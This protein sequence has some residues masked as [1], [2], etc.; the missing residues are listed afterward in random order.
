M[1]RRVD[2]WLRLR[3][4]LLGPI[5]AR[6]TLRAGDSPRD[7]YMTGVLAPADA[8]ELD[9]SEAE[10]L[11]PAA[12]E[13]PN[14]ADDEESAILIA[15][16]GASF[17]DPKALPHSFGLSFRVEPGSSADVA[18]T[19]GEYRLD[20][21]RW[22]REPRA[23]VEQ[24]VDLDSS[25]KK[26]QDGLRLHVVPDPVSPG[27]VSLYLENARSGEVRDSSTHIFQPQ[28]RVV[29][30]RGA[31]APV[32]DLRQVSSAD[33]VTRLLYRENRPYA[34]GHLVGVA[35][36]SIDPEASMSPDQV[37]AFWPDGG[38]NQ[39][40]A[41]FVAPDVRTEFLPA[42]EVPTPTFD[43]V[44]SDPPE[45]AAATLANLDGSDL[46]ARLGPLSLAY[47]AWVD[48]RRTA[49]PFEVEPEDREAAEANLTQCDRIAERVREGIELIAT[50][51]EARLAF[52]F[53]MQA[54]D[55]QSTW[56]GRPGFTWRPFQLAFILLSLPSVTDPN[57][58]D[59]D[60][61][62]LLWFATGG[63]MTE[64]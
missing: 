49:M 11:E 20:D 63:G 34:R 9:V 26:E 33:A 23:W 12:P 60:T 47:A 38:Q 25:V 29:L 41:L 28:I 45:L 55:R 2:L 56:Q 43:W 50:D 58:A 5:E 59:R 22:R 14:D 24:A 35:W 31:L 64:A 27:R 32:E 53:A 13:A 19:W 17:L 37:R 15:P 44:G 8:D 46:R 30:V 39:N 40:L 62:D 6:E 57:H 3:R 54:I 52:A 51:T 1:G 48:G 42:V 10:L 16:T 4:E 36:K 61:C 18:I 21:D 7:L